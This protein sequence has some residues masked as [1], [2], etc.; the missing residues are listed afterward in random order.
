A[1]ESA[2][3]RLEA[4]RHPDQPA[5]ALGHEMAAVGRP[6][7]PTAHEVEVRPGTFAQVP[8]HRQTLGLALGA[9]DER[10]EDVLLGERSHGSF[11]VIV[12][13]ELYRPRASVG[14]R[15]RGRE[16][17]SGVPAGRRRNAPA[18][19]LTAWDRCRRTSRSVTP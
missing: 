6:G 17:F 12:A 10:T 2:P 9:V 13:P 18:G 4:Q 1:Q 7:V 5:V 15:R 3:R 11:S 14:T 19:R 16:R 8:G